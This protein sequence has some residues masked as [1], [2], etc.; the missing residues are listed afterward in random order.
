MVQFFEPLIL[1]SGEKHYRKIS[2]LL[3]LQPED[4]VLDVACG[5]GGDR[6]G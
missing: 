6:P 3:D 2:G 1:L 4:D 5:N